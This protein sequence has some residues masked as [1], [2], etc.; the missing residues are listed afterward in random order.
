M[1]VEHAAKRVRNRLGDV[2]ALDEHGIQTGD[3]ARFGSPAS[4]DQ[5][6]DQREHARG[7]ALRR[8]GL[9]GGQPDFT[10]RHR[11][12]RRRIHQ[13]QYVFPQISKILGD[14]GRDESGANPQHGRL[15][16]RAHDEHAS[17]AP[18]LPEILAQEVADLPPALADECHNCDIGIREPGDH[19]HEH[20]FPDSGSRENAHTLPAANRVHR[21]DRPNARSEWAV[22][23]TTRKR[24]R[25]VAMHR[26]VRFHGEIH[27]PTDRAPHAVEHRAQHL[28]SHGNVLQAGRAGHTISNR[29][30]ERR[31]ERR[32]DG[33]VIAQSH[34]LG[35]HGT[36]M[37]APNP[38]YRS[39]GQGKPTR[40]DGHPGQFDHTTGH[41][42]EA[43]GV[44]QSAMV[45][46]KLN[47]R[48]APH[49]EPAK[50]VR[51]SAYRVSHRRQCH[52]SSP[53]IRLGKSHHR[54]RS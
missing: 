41:P 39:H 52:R 23:R 17:L 49:R 32:K 15:V 46:K 8:R 20:A 7:I 18:F 42:Q 54:R 2:V 19:P 6:R 45:G 25:R 44:D 3:A 26:I 29:H 5:T 11:H 47:H 4:F 43:R 37:T 10:L 33:P 28:A 35:G 12:S 40:D 1:P 24:R 30:T 14:R 36:A 13:Q 22:D 53:C 48:R 16:R 31:L 38:A 27:A 51:Q 50:R 21:V 34:H 9:P